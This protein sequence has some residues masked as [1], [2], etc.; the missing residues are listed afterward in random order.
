[1]HGSG[2]LAVWGT[3]STPPVPSSSPPTPFP[4]LSSARRA[5]GRGARGCVVCV[6]TQPVHLRP[7]AAH[8]ARPSHPPGGAQRQPGPHGAPGERASP[9]Q[10]MLPPVQ[11]ARSPGHG[12]GGG[13]RGP[14]PR[15]SLLWASHGLLAKVLPGL[16]CSVLFQ[17]L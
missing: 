9:V 7:L 1:M 8:L 2:C 11:A 10:G 4:V 15:A 3:S 13:R 6:H 14:G 16:V 5:A 17:T 12:E